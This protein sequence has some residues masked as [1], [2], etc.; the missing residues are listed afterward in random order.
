MIPRH[1]NPKN[2]QD[3]FSSQ[4]DISGCFPL[5]VKLDLAETVQFKQHFPMNFL[6]NFISKTIPNH[7]LSCVT[8]IF[9]LFL[10]EGFVLVPFCLCSALWHMWAFINYSECSQ[11]HCS[12]NKHKLRPHKLIIFLVL[13]S[14]MPLEINF[15][16]SKKLKK[17]KT[18]LLQL[19]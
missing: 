2:L 9:F 6:V 1:P 12:R 11:M 8:S 3:P 10:K 4:N 18:L 17:K 19:L 13:L 14:C 5:K 16:A 7:E 15:N